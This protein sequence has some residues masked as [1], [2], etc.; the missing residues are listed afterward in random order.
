MDELTF[1]T[2]LTAPQYVMLL[3]MIEHRKAKGEFTTH[4]IDGWF[5][6]RLMGCAAILG[7][8]SWT[9]VATKQ[10]WML[11]SVAENYGAGW[12][13]PADIARDYLTVKY[14]GKKRRMN[15][16]QYREFYDSPRSAPIYAVP[17]EIENALYIDIKSAY[18]SI[19]R[20][21][22]WDVDYMPN[23]FLSVCSD[24][25]DFPFPDNKMARNCLVSTAA[26]GAA[27]MRMWT[28]EQLSWKKGGNPLVNKML[29]SLVMDVLHGVA[30]DCVEAGACYVY[31]DG[32][33]LPEDKAR[34][35][36][37]VL[38]A[39]GLPCGIKHEG[40]TVILGAGAYKIGAYE[41][42]KFKT[43]RRGRS[44]IKVRKR[45]RGDWLRDRFS[46]WAARRIWV[47]LP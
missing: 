24:V 36:S 8:F 35:V 29:W 42:K 1:N 31:T 32:F 25:R 2:K 40:R 11:K 9:S 45:D 20:A 33:I 16:K 6:P 37:D 3:K 38:K 44:L 12:V 27:Y 30:H 26:E 22:G 28:G 19:L 5:P 41:T 14:G 21:V 17:C 13:T 43:V 15:T 39:W 47:D 34:S 46:K 23:S 7:S 10:R 18:W 4:L